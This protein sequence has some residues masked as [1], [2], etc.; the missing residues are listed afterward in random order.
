MVKLPICYV[1]IDI[2]Q[3]VGN[4]I[5]T[6]KIGHT[7][8][9]PW[10][11]LDSL[12]TGSS[13]KLH[14][15][16]FS[17]LHNEAE[18]LERYKAFR[19]IGEWFK[20]PIDIYTELITEL[21]HG[22]TGW[23]QRMDG[24]FQET[25]TQPRYVHSEIPIR[26]P[27]VPRNRIESSKTSVISLP[28]PIESICMFYNISTSLWCTSKCKDGK[29]V[30]GKHLGKIK[31]PRQI[32]SF[33][34]YYGV[35]YES[36]DTRISY[37]LRILRCLPDSL[38]YDNRI[39][40]NGCTLRGENIQ[41]LLE[42]GQLDNISRCVL[43]VLA[44]SGISRT[45]LEA[46]LPPITT[47]YDLIERFSSCLANVTHFGIFLGTFYDQ[48]WS[49]DIK[50]EDI[51]NIMDIAKLVFDSRALAEI[52]YY[53]DAIPLSTIDD[54]KDALQY[55]DDYY[56]MIDAL[57]IIFRHR[58]NLTDNI[59]LRLTEDISEKRLRNRHQRFILHSVNAHNEEPIPESY[60]EITESEW[61]VIQTDYPHTE[62][63]ELDHI[64]EM[65][66]RFDLILKR[67]SSLLKY[68]LDT[69]II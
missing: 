14:V 26:I 29:L 40:E 32:S 43:A 69:S 10:A 34:D 7:S 64:T 18:M 61:N 60:D 22:L 63:T 58:Y 50:S 9:D 66:Y 68:V 47:S 16:A 30:C 48:M 42:T 45:Q 33:E 46:K 57:R 65:D 4:P 39:V 20:L 53:I 21:R 31:H 8:G 37:V 36:N 28:K 27:I 15:A 49:T 17:P 55:W 51:S 5:I 25:T 13:N 3:S 2:E 1:L 35:E 44:T 11:R 6:A 52:G 24:A 38:L 59:I 62:D 67:N 54:W 56:I 12:Q 41:K 19:T 23:K